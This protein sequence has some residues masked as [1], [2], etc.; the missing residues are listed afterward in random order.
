MINFQNIS[1]KNRS[2]Q[3]NE[4]TCPGYYYCVTN[5]P[6]TKW[7][8]TIGT[9]VCIFIFLRFVSQEFCRAKLGSCHWESLI[10]L[11]SDVGQGCR[12]G[13]TGLGIQGGTLNWLVV[14]VSWGTGFSAMALYQSAQT[15]P[16]Q[17]DGLKSNKWLTLE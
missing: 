5:C 16:F 8:K 7:Y 4:P 11:Q 6:Q 17:L 9:F 10:R 1:C 2:I 13:C 14:D 15:W 3:F 12:Q